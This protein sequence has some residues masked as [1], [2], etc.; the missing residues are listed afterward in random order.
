MNKT[1]YSLL[2]FKNV[3]K[4]HDDLKG[5]KMDTRLILAVMAKVMPDQFECGSLES[6]K[7]K[8]EY[9]VFDEI[10]HQLKH[11]FMSRSFDCRQFFRNL[12][13]QAST[14]AIP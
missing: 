12:N 13:K 10:M 1:N 14:K 5:M 6:L 11:F 9:N 3:A 2:W 7:T 8:D 4:K